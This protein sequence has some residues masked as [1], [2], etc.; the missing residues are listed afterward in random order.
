MNNNSKINTSEVPIPESTATGAHK[1]NNTKKKIAIITSFVVLCILGAVSWFVLYGI[2]PSGDNANPMFNKDKDKGGIDGMYGNTQ[3]YI[4]YPIDHDMDI[5]TEKEYLDLD[6]FIYYTKGA[7][8]I[9]LTDDELEGLTDDVLFFIKYF[10]LAI[11]GNYN[12]Y[13]KLFTDNYYKSNEAYY[14]FTQQMIYDMHIEKLGENTVD[15]QNQYYFN[16][17]YKIHKNNGTFRNDIG[18]DG[19]KTLYFTLVDT[20]NGIMIDAINYYVKG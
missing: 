18:S 3:T 6:R 17:S 7:E 1:P 8:T 9:A 11:S 20:E 16:V 4:Y 12:A 2:D 13:N 10:D 19:S 15:G 14:S 5:M